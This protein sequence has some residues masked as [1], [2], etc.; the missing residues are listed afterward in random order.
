VLTGGLLVAIVVAGFTVNAA[1]RMPCRV[2]C[3][4]DIGR[5][6]D[7]RGIDRAHPPFF[8]RPFEYPPLTG[9]V[10]W[11]AAAPFPGGLRGPFLVNALVLGALAVATTWLLWR[12]HGPATRRWALAPPLLVQGLTNW[13]LLAVAPATI[14]L[15]AWESGASA[16]AGALLG[17]GT[18]AKLYPALFVPVL[19]A[20]CVPARAWGR[21]RAL[22][23]GFAGGAAVFTIP[24]YA[25][26][27][28]ALEHFV[29]F[30][31]ARGPG[32][33][34]LWY[35]LFRDPWMEPWL[36]HR[37]APANLGASL[38]AGTALIVLVVRVARGRL[39]PVAGCALATIAFLL[40]NKIYSPQY[41]LWLV[42]F[43]VMLPVR[44]ALV[45]HFY[46]ASVLVFGLIA[47]AREVFGHPLSLQLTGAAVVYRLAVELGIAR[48]VWR[49]PAGRAPA[50]A[51]R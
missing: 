36:E 49:T 26:A 19:A 29:S 48:Q 25:F 3:G 31:R 13:D 40:A 41:D 34:S 35:W 28:Q 45:V 44:T 10:M 22:V 9:L 18:A 17:A 1:V 7:D 38:L 4:A 20:S 39:G 46:F 8:D 16:A 15:L 32:R 14:G 27:P 30:H 42:P 37:T 23:A 12:R 6:Y 21:L 43:F 5:L 11:G 2:V 33:G 50:S 24:V 51:R 47:G